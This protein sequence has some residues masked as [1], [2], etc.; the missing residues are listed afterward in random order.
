[1]NKP[2]VT[3]EDLARG[4][5]M[6]RL[7]ETISLPDGRQL[8][9]LELGDPKGKPA[10]YFHGFP[11]SRLE[12]AI[13]NVRGI[14]LISID[15]PGYGR[16]DPLPKRR[17]EDW[18]RDV[19]ALAHHLNLDRFSVVGVSGGAPYAAVCAYALAPRIAC[20]AF[21]CGLGPPEAPGMG[22][23]HIRLLR[24][25]GEHLQSASR[26]VLGVWRQI[27]L[28]EKGELI[29]NRLVEFA[30]L[31]KKERE[32]LTPEFAMLITQS[33][34]EGL[35]YSPEGMVSDG[36]IYARPWPFALSDIKTPVLIWH[37]T[38]DQAVPVSIGHYYAAHIRQAEARFPKGEGHFSLVRHH[39][40]EMIA[41]IA[42]VS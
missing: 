12:P 13:L 1:M 35:R 24:T 34:R 11:G 29:A 2:L 33:W 27:L 19:A 9:Y 22:A 28:H 31:S 17:L 37:G 36:A 41:Q 16:S 14:R 15:R 4:R 30:R 6:D 42:M 3:A 10:F 8:A 7:T 21:I 18:P 20:A 39:I 32:A 38:D 40:N 26:T 25:A 5:A 23:S